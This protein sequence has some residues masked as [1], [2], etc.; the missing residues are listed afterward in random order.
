MSSYHDIIQENR[1]ESSSYIGIELNDVRCLGV[2]YND[3]R[4][5]K[6]S[7]GIYLQIADNITMWRNNISVFNESIEGSVAEDF[8]LHAP[9]VINA[10][11]LDSSLRWEEVAPYSPNCVL[12][13]YE[14]PISNTM[15]MCASKMEQIKHEP[16]KQTCSTRSCLLEQRSD[17]TTHNVEKFEKPRRIRTDTQ[18]SSRILKVSNSRDK[19]T[20]A[21]NSA[22]LKSSTS[23]GRSF[24]RSSNRNSA[25]ELAEKLIAK[26][27]A[28]LKRQ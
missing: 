18:V 20:E 15:S 23:S 5:H 26:A 14:A 11:N 13:P 8:V 21:Q 22:S 10:A 7:A 9:S 2:Y 24:V 19:Y 1:V 28:S 3:I 16:Q 25:D 12:K 4:R 27:K 17:K 6:T